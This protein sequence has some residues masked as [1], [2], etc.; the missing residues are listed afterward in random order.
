[1]T[2]SLTELLVARPEIERVEVFLVDVNGV[3]RG[4][5]LPRAK[6]LELDRAGLPLPRSAYALDIWGCDVADA[7][8]AF[9]T[10]DPDGWCHP[11]PGTA[12]P[13]SWAARPTAGVMLAMVNAD[14]G[15][16]HADPRGVLQAVVGRLEERGL[17]AVVATEL[18]FYL[19]ERGSDDRTWPPELDRG[20]WAEAR[21]DVLSIAALR[22]HE[23]LFDDIVAACAAQNVPSE[24]ILRENAAGQYEINLTH[25]ADAVRAADYAVLLKQ[26]VKGCAA[27][28]DLLAS[29][30]AKP[31][32]ARAGS[33]MHIHCSLSSGGTPV[34]AAADGAVS[35]LLYHAVAGLVRRLP[36]IMLC[37][38]PHANSY[39]R[40]SANSHAPTRADWGIDD[41]SAAVRVIL[42]EAKAVRI[43]QRV[44]GADCNP[45]LAVAGTLSA[46][47]DG[48]D[49]GTAPA[50][51]S[52]AQDERGAELP[53]EW[54]Q[55]INAFAGSAFVERTFGTA[56]CDVYLA[57]KRQDQAKM[58][59][60]VSDVELDAYLVA[61]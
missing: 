3:P 33:G 12:A 16:F 18:E 23:A 54:S 17:Q 53:T 32:G 50:A 30:M 48:L 46:I 22:R 57:C 41:R 9:G 52:E 36:E 47:L 49:T 39:R 45:Y 56:F 29:F 10:G 2:A 31:D 40:F 38:A 58:L 24:T 4:K 28:H 35:D 34:F 44:A 42:G 59:A 7:G 8:L 20:R 14:G 25:V 27:R 1:M 51:M 15:P 21:N 60:R 26:I 6:A 55:A 13:M 5:W 61:S 11:V 19:F 37:L 43:E